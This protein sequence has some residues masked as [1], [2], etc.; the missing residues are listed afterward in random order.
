MSVSESGGLTKRAWL[1]R[2]R[3][4]R[5]RWPCS[6]QLK[7]VF[8]AAGRVRFRGCPRTLTPLRVIREILALPSARGNQT[9]GTA[10][11]GLTGLEAYPCEPE[12]CKKSNITS[13]SS[14]A[15]L[16]PFWLLH[17]GRLCVRQH[18]LEPRSPDIS[19]TAASRVQHVRDSS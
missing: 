4:A 13:C 6:W 3:H 2:Q 17:N 16:L 11:S 10:V 14:C 5:V 12:P 9:G 1:G 15:L 8:I 7:T 18:F 19:L